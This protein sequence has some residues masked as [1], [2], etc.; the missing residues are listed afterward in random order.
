MEIT[1]KEGFDPGKKVV[2]NSNCPLDHRCPLPDMCEFIVQ[3]CQQ[4]NT[5]PPATIYN[6]P[7]I[8]QT[9]C[10]RC[11]ICVKECRHEALEIVEI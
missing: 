7:E 3:S 11:G 5:G 9:K 10:E 1:A 4:S 6:L 2:V 8:D